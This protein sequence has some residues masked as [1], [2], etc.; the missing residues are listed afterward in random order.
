MTVESSFQYPSD[1]NASYPAAGD[2][3]SEGDDH[4][5]GIKSVLKTTLPNVTGAITAT[6][7]EL[8]IMD[9]VTAST[10]EL[11]ILD[12]VTATA[13]ELNALDGI[14]ASVAEL[15]IMDGV[16]ATAAEINALDGITATV[17]ELNYTDGVTSPIQTQ[18]DLKAPLASP[19]L[20]GVP[21]APTASVGTGTTQIAT[22]AF[23]AATSLVSAL[24]AQTG[25][26]GKTVTTDGTNASWVTV[27]TLIPP[28]TQAQ[29]EAMASTAVFVT[30][31]RQHFHPSAAKVWLKCDAAG[32]IQASFNVTSIT[33]VGVGQLDVVIAT[34]FSSTEYPVVGSAGGVSAYVFPTS[35]AAGSFSAQARTAADALVDPVTGWS[36]IAFGDQV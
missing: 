24:P 5:R 9:G 28:A 4:L 12:G 25:N 33:D 6:Q 16:T 13:A 17:T 35:Q 26:S 34:D 32:A 1:L 3:K 7:A 11:N 31:A 27:E 18:M 19:A 29:Q 30:P 21:T 15:N 22:C 10:A 2:N 20:T 14:T 8:N 36:L 23:V